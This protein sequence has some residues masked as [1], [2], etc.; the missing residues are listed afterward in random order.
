MQAAHVLRNPVSPTVLLPVH[1]CVLWTSL[2]WLSLRLFLL[3]RRGTLCDAS[4]GNRRCRVSNLLNGMTSRWQ[5]QT[6]G[7]CTMS[8]NSVYLN[9]LVNLPEAQSLCHRLPS[10]KTE[11]QLLEGLY[12]RERV[13][14]QMKKLKKHV[15][16]TSCTFRP[17]VS[18][19]LI[20]DFLVCETI[21]WLFARQRVFARKASVEMF[22]V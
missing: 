10:W 5:R 2:L 17:K 8:S 6:A 13:R 20:N 14:R 15:Q 16:S 1:I 7:A 4:S 18:C 12:S 19:T 3:D 9:F 21:F 22:G 11:S